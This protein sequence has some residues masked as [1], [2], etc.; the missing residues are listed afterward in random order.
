[1][2]PAR[3]NACF[4]RNFVEIKSAQLQETLIDLRTPG[5]QLAL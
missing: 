1:M 4:A 3:L 5:L 2:L